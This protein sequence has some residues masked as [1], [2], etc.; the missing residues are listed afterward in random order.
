[1]TAQDLFP[2]LEPSRTGFLDVDPPHRIYWEECGNPNGTPILF[3]HGGPGAGCSPAHRTFF[4]PAHYRIFLFDQRGAGQSTPHGELSHNTT[5]HL[6]AD[7]ER[8]RTLW[9]IETWHVFGGSW[10]S[11][12]A[13]AYAEAHPERVSAL[14]LRGI[15]L[16][17]RFEI[18]WFMKGLRIMHPAA[19]ESFLATLP[20]DQRDNPLPHLYALL[21]HPDPG[22]H[23]PIARA[24]CLYELSTS[25]LLPNADLVAMVNNDRYSLGMARIEAHYFTNSLFTPDDQLLQNVDK[26]RHI[27]AVIVQGQYDLVCPPCSAHDLHRAWPEAE[28]HVIP[29]AGHSAFEP[30]IKRALVAATEK[31]KA[32]R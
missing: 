17:R 31:M 14:I 13:L 19:S 6:I 15:F 28:Y 10:G 5:T 22:I 11:T 25:T 2:P 3:L 7:I 30:G 32:I 8:L 23:M 16:L 9:G 20:P 29:D 1:M 4:D 12:L 21:T 26:I 27:P 18:D 24:W